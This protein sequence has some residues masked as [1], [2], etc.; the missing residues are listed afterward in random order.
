MW[1]KY[2]SIAIHEISINIPGKRMTDLSKLMT[3]QQ[4]PSSLEI[5]TKSTREI[6]ETI[7]HEDKKVALAVEEALPAISKVVDRICDCFQKGGRLLYVGAG[8][9]GRLGVLDASECP[10]TYGTPPDMVQGI[11]AG[12][13]EALTR[14]IEG[15]ED[16]E[17][18]GMEAIKKREIDD[19]DMVIGITASGQAPFVIGAMIEARKAG[20]CVSALGC[21]KNSEIFQYA[22]YTIFIDVGAEIIAGSTRMKAGTAQKLVLNMIT[23]AAM[24]KMGKV[25]GNLMVDLT[26]VNQKLE[27]RSIRLIETATGCDKETAE[28]VFQSS[29]KKPKVAIVMV[30]LG[31]EKEEAVKRLNENQGRISLVVNN[32]IET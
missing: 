25:F 5:D 21:N 1:L 12:G 14:S 15:A 24:I 30:L 16:D 26:P 19:H 18:K 7:N 3:E 17:Q 29:E 27:H 2:F 11:I 32:N 10:P 4:N 9:S 23:T 28:K 8:T 13:K 6:L 20:A 22:D 31:I